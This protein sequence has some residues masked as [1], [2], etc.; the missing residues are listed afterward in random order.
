MTAIQEY[1]G[2][3]PGINQNMPASIVAESDLKECSFRSTGFSA[4]W[5]LTS[6]SAVHHYVCGK[7]MDIWRGEGLQQLDKLP[8]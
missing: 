3:T 7:E 6:G 8:E 1:E 2:R 5:T 4:Q